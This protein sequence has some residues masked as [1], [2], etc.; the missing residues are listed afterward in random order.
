ML[1]NMPY[2]TKKDRRTYDREYHK[3]KKRQLHA[4]KKALENGDL[5]RA[6]RVLARK[7][8]IH[9]RKSEKRKRK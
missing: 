8:R 1:M 5:T 2:K 7:P 6:K 4:I 3:F 9:V